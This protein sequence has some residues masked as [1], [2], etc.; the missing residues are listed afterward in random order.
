MAKELTL[1][2]KEGALVEVDTCNLFRTQP[3]L[4]SCS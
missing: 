1:I 2:H 3:Y 4:F